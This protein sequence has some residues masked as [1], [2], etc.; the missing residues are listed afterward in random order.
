MI[1]ALVKAL[2][3][4]DHL[5]IPILGPPGVGKSTLALAALHDDRVAS[6][7]GPRR[8]FVRCDGARTCDALAAEIL[9]ALGAEPRPPL[10]DQAL[11]ELGRNAP[12]VLVLDNGET[13]WEGETRATEELFAALAGVA[14]VM[15][16]VTIRGTQRPGRTAWREPMR[17]PLLDPAA[18]RKAFLAIAGPGHRRDKHLD[19]LLG[20]VDHLPLAVTLLAHLA[21]GSPNLDGLWSRWSQKGTAALT[22]S[23]LSGDRLSDLE[24]SFEL[25]ITGPRMT[26]EARRLLSLL[27]LLPDGIAWDDLD[28]LLPERSAEAAATLRQ[29]GLAYDDR[30]AARLRILAPL[31][32]F[33]SRRHPPDGGNGPGGVAPG[34][35]DLARLVTFFVTMAATL[36]PRAG[37]TGGAEAIQRLLADRANIEA[38]LLRGLAG[39][40]PAAAIMAAVGLAEFARFTGMG[41]P[42]VLELARNAAREL[43]DPRAQA[44]CIQG[45]GD[46]ALA[47]SDHEAA[48]RGY[49]EALPLY[50]RVGSV[51][52][53]ANCIKGLGD[54]ALRRSDHEAARRGF[55]EALPLYHRVGAVLGEANCIQRLGDIALRRSDHEAARRG[56]AEAL[57]LYRRVGD[58]LGEANCIKG[59]GDIARERSDHEAAGRGYEEALSL[60]RRIPEPYSIGWTHVRLARLAAE[61]DERL[62]HARE[63]RVNWQLSRRDDL[64]K[65]LE[66]E[67]GELD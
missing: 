48:R 27:G 11:S 53:E 33:L 6:R 64:V 61:P 10:Q 8:Y 63:A 38:M 15:L 29:V 49:A 42:R 66:T 1:G 24:W 26:A 46:I 43:G 58:V 39:A 30:E 67:F 18:S 5:P 40:D 17:L 57:P 16:V 23:G 55:A 36:G 54:I 22:R 62:R 65:S 2:V 20:A 9:R 7:F 25:S 56:Y 35:D 13:P 50:R 21:E 14:G 19:A 28:A 52:G 37:A 47:R 3:G 12:A 34:G 51:L 45:L 4:Q 41:T 59:L 60:Y 31:R 32:E 44:D